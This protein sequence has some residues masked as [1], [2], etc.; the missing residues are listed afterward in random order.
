MDAAQVAYL[1]DWI[2]VVFAF[3]GVIGALVFIVSVLF[4]LRKVSPI[5][6]SAKITFQNVKGTSSFVSEKVVEPIIKTYGF[7]AGARRTIG[8]ITRLSKRK[9]GRRHGK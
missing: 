4:I 3:L 5:L 8:I 2:I 7:A 6:D 9:G 1:R